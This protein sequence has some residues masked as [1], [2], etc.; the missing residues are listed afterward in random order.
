M[1]CKNDKLDGRQLI[2]RFEGRVPSTYGELTL[3]PGVGDYVAS[4]VLCFAFGKSVAIVDA[5]TVRV[6]GRYFGFPTHP[7]SRR[8]KA[9]REA[10]AKLTVRKNA[11]EFN[12]ALL[13]FA[14]VICKPRDPDCKRCP[15]RMRCAW[16][17]RVSNG[18]I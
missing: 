3:L 4:A 14:A 12:L 8:R 15:V 1:A 6:A 16:W 9:V 11:R 13:D 5:N 18:Q 7:E 17:K 10:V 2:S